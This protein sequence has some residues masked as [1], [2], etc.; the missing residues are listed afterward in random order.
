MHGSIDQKARI[1]SEETAILIE[2]MGFISYGD[3]DGGGWKA[4]TKAENQRQKRKQ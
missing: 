2:V 1:N 3:G 4:R